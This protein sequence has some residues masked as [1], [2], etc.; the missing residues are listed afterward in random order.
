[1][2]KRV[3]RSCSQTKLTNRFVT[4]KQRLK[5]VSNWQSEQLVAELLAFKTQIDSRFASLIVAVKQ[6]CD[7]RKAVKKCHK[8]VSTFMLD[9]EMVNLTDRMQKK[10]IEQQK[11][12][13]QQG[14]YV[15]QDQKCPEDTEVWTPQELEILRISM[16]AQTQLKTPL[17]HYLPNHSASAI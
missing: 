4:R 7:R 13:P 2:T 11:Q 17:R 10:L 1:M 16:E 9:F 6:A 12:I 5:Q 8:F 15:F 3:S 14:I